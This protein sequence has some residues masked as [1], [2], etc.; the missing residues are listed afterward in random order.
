MRYRLQGVQCQTYE[1]ILKIF[2]KYYKGFRSQAFTEFLNIEAYKMIIRRIRYIIQTSGR[3]I[4]GIIF[5]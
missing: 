2:L 4:C 3:Q 5:F 1:R